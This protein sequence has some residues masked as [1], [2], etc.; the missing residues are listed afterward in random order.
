MSMNSVDFFFVIV[1]ANL[2]YFNV[3]ATL[4][5]WCFSDQLSNFT[6]EQGIIQVP[7]T[8]QLFGDCLM[9]SRGNHLWIFWIVKILK[10]V[11]F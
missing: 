3:R 10:R 1:I 4:C 8:Q 7:E 11:C 6:N 5:Y 2:F 9:F